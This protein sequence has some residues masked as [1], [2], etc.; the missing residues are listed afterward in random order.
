MSKIVQK[1]QKMTNIMKKLPKNI[2]NKIFIAK[3]MQK[4]KKKWD[5]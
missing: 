4:K 5:N 2:K 1:V 3:I